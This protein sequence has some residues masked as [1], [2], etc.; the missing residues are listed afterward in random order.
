MLRKEHIKAL[1][2]RLLV[3]R[4]KISELHFSEYLDT[5]VAEIFVEAL[6]LESRTVYVIFIYE[7]LGSV[8]RKIYRFK[9][10]FVNNSFEFNGKFLFSH[11]LF[12]FHFHQQNLLRFAS[13]SKP[14]AESFAVISALLTSRSSQ[15]ASRF[16]YLSRSIVFT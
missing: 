10:E 9:V 5:G 14:A 7:Y 3:K 6:K 16:A 13:Y 1:C 2:S 11:F 8:L 4:C 15:S 12:L